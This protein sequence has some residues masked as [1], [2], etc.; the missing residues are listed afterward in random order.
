MAEPLVI[1]DDLI[2]YLIPWYHAVLAARPEAYCS[3]VEVANSEPDSETPFPA[4]LLVINDAGGPETSFLTGERTVSMSIL[5]GTKDHPQ[6]ANDLA[7]M[8][9]ALRSQVPAPG[10]ET[11]IGGTTY[12][13]PVTAVVDSNGPFEV[14]EAQDRA[15]RLLNITFA[16]SGAGL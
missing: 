3:D 14:E 7:R 4:R 12:R 8:V 2:G 11:V 1:D 10:F 15:R 6:D 16:V 5:A 13:N 9:R